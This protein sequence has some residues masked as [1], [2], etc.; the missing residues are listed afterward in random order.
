MP[1]L[2]LDRIINAGCDRVLQTF[3]ERQ[4]GNPDPTTVATVAEDGLR[5]VRR[6][7]DRALA[8]A[9]LTDT[10]SCQ[11]LE[12][13]G[14]CVLRELHGGD[15]DPH[16]RS[17]MLHQIALDLYPEIVNEV[18][19]RMTTLDV[20][21]SKV[22]P[23]RSWVRSELTEAMRRV[24]GT[25]AFVNNKDA[26]L[27]ADAVLHVFDEVCTKDEEL[28]ADEFEAFVHF[29]HAYI[30]AFV[31]V[32]GKRQVFAQDLFAAFQKEMD[33][34]LRKV[35]S[36]CMPDAA[37][38]LQRETM[39][40]EPAT[41]GGKPI[42][43]RVD[44]HDTRQLIGQF[45]AALKDTVAAAAAHSLKHRGDMRRFLSNRFPPLVADAE[46]KAAG[47]ICCIADI[48]RCAVA[49]S[50]VAD[51]VLQ[52]LKDMPEYKDACR[53]SLH[54]S[55]REMCRCF[56][57]IYPEYRDTRPDGSCGP[58]PVLE[59]LVLLSGWEQIPAMVQQWSQGARVS[60]SSSCKSALQSYSARLASIV[61]N[62][63]PDRATCTEE[64]FNFESRLDALIR[65]T[66]HRLTREDVQ[67]VERVSCR[68]A[69]K[70]T[71]DKYEERFRLAKA[72][73]I[74]RENIQ[75]SYV[76][77]VFWH[78][79]HFAQMGVHPR[80]E[81]AAKRTICIRQERLYF[82]LQ[83]R[84]CALPATVRDRRALERL[85]ATARR[86]TDV[87]LGNLPDLEE[88]D[89]KQFADIQRGI[90]DSFEHGL[91]IRCDLPTLPSSITR[92]ELKARCEWE[93]L[94][95]A[96]EAFVATH[97]PHMTGVKWKTGKPQE[98]LATI[99]QCID[100]S[101]PADIDEWGAIGNLE[102]AV[103]MKIGESVEKTGSAEH[104][105]EDFALHTWLG[106]VTLVCLTADIE[107]TTALRRL[108]CCDADALLALWC[109][110]T[111]LQESLCRVTSDL[112]ANSSKKVFAKLYRDCTDSLD[113]IQVMF[114]TP[115]E[116]WPTMH[117]AFD[118]VA[119]ASATFVSAA[120]AENDPD[121]RMAGEQLERVLS[122]MMDQVTTR[123][124]LS[125]D[126]D[127]K[128]YPVSFPSDSP[129][130][131]PKVPE[132]DRREDPAAATLR[133]IERL[134]GH[135]AQEC[136]RRFQPRYASLTEDERTR[137][138]NL[139]HDAF[140][141]LQ[142]SI[143]E[144]LVDPASSI[145]RPVDDANKRVKNAI[146]VVPAGLSAPL[147]AVF[148]DCVL[149]LYVYLADL[150]KG[151][152]EDR[153]RLLACVDDA[154]NAREAIDFWFPDPVLKSAEDFAEDVMRMYGI[155]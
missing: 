150:H 67:P 28:H 2:E 26:A 64:L 81:E 14:A 103:M 97:F 155:V 59:R 95:P 120:K 22:I 69:F 39:L 116:D 48:C 57:G 148:G 100:E 146:N 42:H 113:R 52:V 82:D 122:W 18:R 123:Y 91:A 87:L 111:C 125:V 138:R 11:D 46:G 70:A 76:R 71:Y 93:T 151:S 127:V 133:H 153:D 43:A 58:L 75:E 15:V 94:R 142:I 1:R 74:P 7:I 78:G 66:D 110:D 49:L 109:K 30:A 35:C 77:Q 25:S 54:N 102:K 47:G 36:L 17:D 144:I 98:F 37:E 137:C 128:R 32:L 117:R 118:I 6:A 132:P 135:M 154:G 149:E 89:A 27:L 136:A 86:E 79:V 126:C 40:S 152:Q 61:R 21:E 112:G 140:K 31:A 29:C 96:V 19:K 3:L 84:I 34:L 83:E 99:R 106:L 13:A 124:D 44:E 101:C 68:L 4:S 56:S 5:N 107:R 139:L 85:V 145:L 62:S 51:E 105:D 9:S 131:S 129:Y 16:R 92:E 55:V 143:G 141:D 130:W 20:D 147:A 65:D 8:S 33:P 41:K 72:R 60:L 108:R 104:A 38:L 80:S 114:P 10:C 63:V 23:C 53:S 90:I 134:L 121:V 12:R 50:S 115:I 119:A 45:A 24:R 73:T 88:K